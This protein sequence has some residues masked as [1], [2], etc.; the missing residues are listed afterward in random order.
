MKILKEL[1]S[2]SSLSRRPQ[3]VR[4][5][6]PSATPRAS[7][8]LSFALKTGGAPADGFEG[9]K[10][11]HRGGFRSFALFLRNFMLHRGTEINTSLHSGSIDS[12]QKSEAELRIFEVRWQKAEI[13]AFGKFCISSRLCLVLRH[14]LKKVDENLPLLLSFILM[15]IS[16]CRE[17]IHHNFS[18]FTLHF[19]RA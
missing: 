10:P 14:L 19:S 5:R 9:V 8:A 2:K 3:T 12:V 18:L 16:E 7:L 6:L 1:F 13:F 4:K 11:P 15:E 17:E